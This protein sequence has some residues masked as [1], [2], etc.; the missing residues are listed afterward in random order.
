MKPSLRRALRIVGSLGL[1]LATA[2]WVDV[3]AVV[4]ELSAAR[5]GPS[6]IALGLSLPLMATLAGRWSFTA[7]R[8]GLDMP[9]R[10]AVAEYYAS[11]F[12]NKV[13]PGGVLG[14]VGRAVRGGRRNPDAKGAMVR[15]VL[16]ERFSGQVALWVFVVVGLVRWGADEGRRVAIAVGLAVLLAGL[17]AAALS[18][19]PR[20]AQSGF[21]RAW[22]LVMTEVRRAFLERGAWAVQLGLSLL[23][24]ALLVAIYAACTQ[25]VGAQVGVSQLLFI[26]PV[27]LAV[28]TLPVSVGGW[29]IREVASIALFEMTG[30]DPAAGVA[31][32][33]AFGGLNLLGSLPG[34]VVLLRRAPA[35][36]QTEQDDE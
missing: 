1:L 10:V 13:L 15:S 20:F 22:T 5:I 18:R 9:M 12:L 19:V 23:S 24:V 17:L 29:G 2:L 33:A 14:D 36:A 3:G 7:R 27:L 11:T 26:A 30:L 28:T 6:L 8:L 25:A 32:S 34:A 35:S 21:G 31:A 4:A 16:L